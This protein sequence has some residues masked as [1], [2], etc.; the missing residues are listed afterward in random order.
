METSGAIS[1]NDVGTF[2]VR[3]SQ[4]S[5]NYAL[6]YVDARGITVHTLVHTKPD[7]SVQLDTTAGE[8]LVYRDLAEL[9]QREGRNLFYPCTKPSSQPTAVSDELLFMAASSNT[10]DQARAQ[11][12]LV[13]IVASTSHAVD[14]RSSDHASPVPAA[15]GIDLSNLVSPLFEIPLDEIEPKG[16]HNRADLCIGE[17]TFGS[18]YRGT[19]RDLEV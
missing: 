17:G 9:V 13:G 18:V 2:L 15:E 11:E 8:T 7:A 4:V 10:V 14:E 3:F 16:F 1:I 5:G 19:W 6:S 12:M